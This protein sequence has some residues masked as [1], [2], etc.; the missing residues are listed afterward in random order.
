MVPP[1]AEEPASIANANNTMPASPIFLKD[2]IIISPLLFISFGPQFFRDGLFKRN[3]AEALA[4]VV[5]VLRPLF[6]TLTPESLIF[7]YPNRLV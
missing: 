5:M 7:L 3:Y 2:T 4:T 1:W 6:R